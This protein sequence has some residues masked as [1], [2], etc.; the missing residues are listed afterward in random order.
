[1]GEVHGSSSTSPTTLPAPPL[2][3]A[4]GSTPAREFIRALLEE[5]MIIRLMM[6]C[7][8]LPDEEAT[9]AKI[10]GRY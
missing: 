1:M 6:N 10:R 9:Q 4:V 7:E 8:T 2:S 3:S 5:I